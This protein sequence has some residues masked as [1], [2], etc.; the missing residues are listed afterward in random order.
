MWCESYIHNLSEG[1]W[2][3]YWS[4][5]RSLEE[6]WGH[7]KSQHEKAIKDG[8]VTR[9]G[10]EGEDEEGG[11]KVKERQTEKPE[12]KRTETERQRKES[13]VILAQPPPL[14]PLPPAG[15]ILPC[16]NIKCMLLLLS[17]RCLRFLK[18]LIQDGSMKIR[19]DFP[20]Q[21]GVITLSW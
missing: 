7:Q 20:V 13:A 14:F 2:G 5:L 9:H 3:G 16:Q 4:E 11:K 1:K 10:Q 15:S 8:S 12:R 18:A 21:W 19:A 6:H 17:K